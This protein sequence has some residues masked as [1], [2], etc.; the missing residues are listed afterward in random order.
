MRV[1]TLSLALALLAPALSAQEQEKEFERPA[2]WVVRF[3]RGGQ[4]DDIYFVEMPPGWHVTTGPAAILYDP[5]RTA[6]GNY[7]VE[8]QIYLFPVERREAFGVFIGG[9]E[10]DGS[11]QAY[12]YFLIRK[13]GS[14]LIKERA[15]SDTRVIHPWTVH[16]A[17]VKHD[18]GEGTAK[19][20]LAIDAGGETVRFLVN[21]QEVA[22]LPRTE[23]RTDGIVGLRVNHGLNVHVSSLEVT[24]Q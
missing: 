6:Q 12:T 21:G 23:L 4:P 5:A 11:G 20:V 17:I 7:G 18:G 15:G 1:A 13:D 16:E 3:D 14:F 22:N 2:D 8:S 24:P 19:N 10:L 9:T